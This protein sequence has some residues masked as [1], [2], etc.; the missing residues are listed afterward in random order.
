MGQ[1]DL[2]NGSKQLA[3]LNQIWLWVKISGIPFWLV[4]EFT[5]HFGIYFGGDWDVHW[6]YDLDLDPWPYESYC[7]SRQILGGPL[8]PNFD[9]SRAVMAAIT[10]GQVTLWHAM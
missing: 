8:V 7:K 5:T 10:V 4:G 6:G 2:E 9:L 3:F 1:A